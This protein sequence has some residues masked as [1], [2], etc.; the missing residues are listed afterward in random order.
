MT[1][2]LCTGGCATVAPAE[3]EP[4]EDRA[5]TLFGQVEFELQL[6]DIILLNPYLDKESPRVD[7]FDAARFE[8]VAA[9]EFLVGYSI[10]VIEVARDSTD[11]D[12]V[13]ESVSLI[14]DL[15]SNL[16]Q[17][18]FIEQH[19]TGIDV[20]AVFA[21][22]AQQEAF[23]NVLRAAAP[24]TREI[25]QAL[26]NS[27]DDTNSLFDLAVDETYNKIVDENRAFMTY[28]DNLILRRN[29]ILEKLLLLDSARQG[30]AAAWRKLLED[31]EEIAQEMG[32]AGTMTGASIDR[33]ESI[34]VARLGKIMEVWGYLEPSWTN[35]QETLSELYAVDTNVRNVLK[36]AK[37][38]IEDWDKA[39]RQ[40]AK[41]RPAGF[42]AVTKDLA[43]LALKRASR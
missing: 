40:M 15:Y 36:I 39:Q 19:F 41:G 35:Y 16:S 7:E 38:I 42:V 30:D 28:T 18:P 4:L 34:V 37:F 2:A 1:L 21:N 11:S 24:V 33:A 9:A 20:D 23:T 8:L 22:A 31:D 32:G 27:V 25:A 12:A 17:L 5:E 3:I 13:A 29:E 6:N 14:R 43:Y 26:A 10:D